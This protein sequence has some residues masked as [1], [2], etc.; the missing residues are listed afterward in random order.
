MVLVFEIKKIF[1]FLTSAF[2]VFPREKK[3]LSHLDPMLGVSIAILLNTLQLFCV[4]FILM[5]T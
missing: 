2:D 4:S 3:Q 5:V 1:S